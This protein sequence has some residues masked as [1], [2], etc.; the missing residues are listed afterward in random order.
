[1]KEIIENLMSSIIAA[2][3]MAGLPVLA[4]SQYRSPAPPEIPEITKPAPDPHLMLMIF[5]GDTTEKAIRVDSAVNLSLCITQGT[6]KVNGWNRNEARVYVENGSKFSFHVRDK[7]PKSGD[8]NWIKVISA[9]T[10]G[11]PAAS[12]C[13]TGSEIEID[14]P[15]NA[16]IAIRGQET[17]TKIDTVKKVEVQT[18]GGDISLRNI[19]GGISARAG[20]GDITVEASTGPILLEST[21]GNIVVFDAGPGSIG[22]SFRAKTTGGTIS[23]QDLQHRQVEV[24]SISGSVLYSGNI[25]NGGSYNLSTSNGSIR[26]SLPADSSCQMQATF[27]AGNFSSELPIKLE[28]E[29]VREGPIKTIVGR[30][31]TGGDATLSLT[32]NNGSISIRKQ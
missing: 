26:M 17:T 15:L 7:D 22:D 8:P 24:R 19:A 31:G 6:V 25:R 1:M 30:L 23:L 10:K 16:T 2:A 29:N 20:Q 3:I 12:E 11:R 32:T 18:I 28:T 13:I 5:G 4:F 21:N 9:E 27:G 14:V